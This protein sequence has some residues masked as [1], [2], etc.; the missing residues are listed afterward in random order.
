M[1][2]SLLL[3]AAPLVIL[4]GCATDGRQ[5]SAAAAGAD[6]PPPAQ[7]AYG[8]FLA[9]QGALNDGKSQEA[10]RFFSA[11]RGEPG[12]DVMIS[13]KAFTAALL[14]GDITR[15][16]A[17]AP[18]GE[19]VSEA[20][21]RLTPLV[22]GVEAMADDHNKVAIAELSSP[23]IAFPHKSAA[24][25]LAP[26][27]AAQAGD[28]EGS[29][30]RPQVRGDKLVDYFGGLGLGLLF[31]RAKRYDEAETELKQ[32]ASG[33]TRSEIG[34]LTYGAFLERRGRRLEA[35]ALYQAA[36]D[37]EPSAQL[38]AAKARAANGRPAPPALT[39]RQGAAQALLAPTASMLAAKQNQ[40]ALAYLRLL[41][42][43]D[44]G[45]DDA[46]VMVGDIMQASGDS[47]AAR[48]AYA[49]PKPGSDEYVEAQGKLAWSYQQA[50][51]SAT[52]LKIARQ[53]AASG[54]ADAR[55][56]LADLLRANEQYAESADLMAQL[57]K[58]TPK[59]DWRLYFGR[60]VSLEKLGRWQEAEA[61]LQAA[62]K[63]KP[64]EPDLL[65]Y[66]GYSW[67][68]RGVH[69]KE[70]IAMVEKAVAANPQSG[71]MVDSLGWA[72]YR[73]GDFKQAVDKLEE[74][75]ELD[76]GDPEVNDHLGDAYW[77]VGRRDEALFQW[78]RVLTLK[79][80]EKIR[81]R[82]EAK[83][84]SPLG[85]DGPAPQIAAD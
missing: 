56:T 71:A 42:R 1:R 15:A 13:E 20:A 14:S 5:P 45:R 51:D 40:I 25:L 79:P 65:N 10:T 2:S 68:D 31:E 47:D 35:V 11:A 53:A 19:G 83:L 18:T 63:L 70:A 37:D 73:L 30:V 43:L 28:V 23:A 21:R 8:M 60:A 44:P 36:L 67:I 46:W 33:D 62:L 6:S 69:L 66:L 4:G 78:R 55:L 82:V 76:A 52:A 49:H 22:R 75:V 41:L 85:P 17:L 38:E 3:F 24:A 32:V 26:W 77:R 57:I 64:D 72:H 54:N 61:D 39:V 48:L 84:A 27:A 16:A 74:A 81:K 80:D 9:G 50:E 7:T 59:P 12:A 34:I 29:L 58:Q